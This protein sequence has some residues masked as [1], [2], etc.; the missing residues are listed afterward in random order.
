M[1]SSTLGDLKFQLDDSLATT[2][3]QVVSGY[4]V[5][6]GGSGGG[7]GKAGD[8]WS[9]VNAWCRENIHK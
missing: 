9:V 4:A 7:V 3:Q 5:P 2:N 1:T 8:E 6:S